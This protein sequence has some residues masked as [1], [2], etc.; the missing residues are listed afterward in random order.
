MSFNDIMKRPGIQFILA[1]LFSIVVLYGVN[2]LIGILSAM[3]GSGGSSNPFG[4]FMNK[5]SL[6]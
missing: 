4:N 2:M 1:V 6:S 3:S 5:I